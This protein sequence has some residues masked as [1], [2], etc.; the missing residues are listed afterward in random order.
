MTSLGN[1]TRIATAFQTQEEGVNSH[2]SYIDVLK[3][4]IARTITKTHGRISS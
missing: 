1:G 2:D 3:T 4:F